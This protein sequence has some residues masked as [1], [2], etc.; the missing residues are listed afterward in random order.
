VRRCPSSTSRLSL[1][2]GCRRA[3]SSTRRA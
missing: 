3:G 1:A 2:L